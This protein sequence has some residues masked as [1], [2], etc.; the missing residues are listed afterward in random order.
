MSR[1][2][3][4]LKGVEKKSGGPRPGTASCS[5]P[6]SSVP[7]RSMLGG[8]LYNNN[9]T[10]LSR[11]NNRQPI[12]NNIQPRQNNTSNRQNNIQPRQNTKISRHV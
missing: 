6:A 7:S 2:D 3:R 10:L 5:L 9:N 1:F 4:R 8:M 12:Q 11:Q